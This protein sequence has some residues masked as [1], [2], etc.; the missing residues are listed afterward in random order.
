MTDTARSSPS[1]GQEYKAYRHAV[2]KRGIPRD[3]ILYI[4]KV[5]T[6]SADV[7][8]IVK[9]RHG[10]T[11][12]LYCRKRFLALF[13]GIGIENDAGIVFRIEI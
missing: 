4:I 11:H 5:R 10:G 9:P 12:T 1:Q 13:A 8:F 7:V 3:D 2:Y 6:L